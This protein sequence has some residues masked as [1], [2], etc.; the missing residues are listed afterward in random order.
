MRGMTGGMRNLARRALGA[1][2][3]P[4]AGLGRFEVLDLVTDPLPPADLVLVRDCVI[5]LPNR[6]ILRALA[7]LQRAG[8]RMLPT[9]TYP[10]CS[11]DPDS[12]IGGFRPI[13]LQRPPFGL[14][15]PPET[16][17]ETEGATS[18]KAMALRDL[19]TL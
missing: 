19:R 8:G 18:G 10:G 17:P 1:L 5:H 9:T 6:A 11:D 4:V 12:E 13:D 16:I 7:N 2:P 15:P 3:A 14:P